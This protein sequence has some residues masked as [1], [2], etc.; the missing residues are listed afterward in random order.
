E[1]ARGRQEQSHRWPSFL[2]DRNHFLYLG[3]GGISMASLDAPESKLLLKAVSSAAYAQGYLLFVRE[4]TLMAQPFDTKR[5]EMAGDAIPIAEQVQVG[6]GGG[7]GAFSV[8]EQG[9]LAYQTGAAG[10]GSQLIWFDRSGKQTGV[11]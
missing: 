7:K 3:R 4:G 8:S 10:G 1:G 11:L 9:I 6:G 5:L 2:P